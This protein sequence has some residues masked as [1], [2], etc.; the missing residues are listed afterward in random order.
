M[1]KNILSEMEIKN[2][3]RVGA[4]QKKF[5]QDMQKFIQDK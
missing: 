5:K 3:E 1:Y 2:E 4:I